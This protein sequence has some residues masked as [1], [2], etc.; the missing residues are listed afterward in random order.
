MSL[1][2]QEL[3]AA[4]DDLHPL[5]ARHN[6]I[7]AAMAYLQREV[8]NLERWRVADLEAIRESEATVWRLTEALRA[9]SRLPHPDAKEIA[10]NALQPTV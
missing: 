9:I 4:L 1:S 6:G 8:R 3:Q 5:I 7:V 10:E 2:E